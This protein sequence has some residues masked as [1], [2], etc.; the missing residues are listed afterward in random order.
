MTLIEISHKLAKDAELDQQKADAIMQAVVEYTNTVAPVTREYLDAR[1]G[2]TAAELRK[3]I[4]DL[5]TEMHKAFRGQTWKLVT[6]FI[7]V[8]LAATVIQHYWH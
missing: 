6:S 2:A 4:A 1:L 5:R 7:V 3:D 8:V